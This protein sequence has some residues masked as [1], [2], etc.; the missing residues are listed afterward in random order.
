MQKTVNHDIAYG[1]I[2]ACQVCGSEDLELVVDLGHQPLCD[3]LLSAKQ[4]NEAEQ[5]YPLR[6]VRCR[7]CSLGQIDYAVNGEVVYHPD[8]PYRSGITRE[9]AEYQ[10]SLSA[11]IIGDLSLPPGSL[12]VDIG[13]N[14]GTLLRGFQNRGIRALGV[15]PTNIAKIANENGIQTYQNFFTEKLA[16]QMVEEHGHASVV[17]TTKYSPTW[18]PWGR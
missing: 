1:Y 14:D 11:E 13:S 5:T 7:V 16:R 9:L 10:D 6:L 18:Q 8:Y 15:E 2:P 4:L 3:S 17:T 12:S